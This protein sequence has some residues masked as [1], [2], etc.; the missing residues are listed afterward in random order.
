MWDLFLREV[1]NEKVD[2]WV[3]H[4]C[5]KLIVFNI[6]FAKSF[7]SNLEIMLLVEYLGSWMSSFSNMLLQKCI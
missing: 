3:S 4:T 6:L 1:I 7:Y 2:I 5:L